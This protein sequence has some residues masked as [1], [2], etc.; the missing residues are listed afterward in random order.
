M[1]H[2]RSC[3]PSGHLGEQTKAQKIRSQKPACGRALVIYPVQ[4]S[5]IPQDACTPRGDTS[6]CPTPCLPLP[7]TECL[8]TKAAFGG[9]ELAVIF[10]SIILN[11]DTEKTSIEFGH[12]N[13]IISLVEFSHSSLVN[14]ST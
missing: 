5:L 1:S 10:T 14:V 9:T 6:H 3:Q 8:P 2:G 13:F 11:M 4:T 12:F 7:R